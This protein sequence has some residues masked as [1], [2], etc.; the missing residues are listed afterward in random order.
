MSNN[1]PLNKTNISNKDEK[2][3]ENIDTEN[4]IN[5]HNMQN[6]P[7]MD[8]EHSVKS[9][10]RENSATIDN[11]EYSWETTSTK[12]V[13]NTSNI[14]TEERVY[15]EIPNEETMKEKEKSLC[16]YLI[17]EVKSHLKINDE[18]RD[19]I[20]YNIFNEKQSITY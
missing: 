13:L 5:M 11:T 17:K 7:K 8:I 20:G 16:V 4:N 9:D 10:Y 19:H 18:K 2:N 1:S 15:D 3:G 14:N 6:G 12:M